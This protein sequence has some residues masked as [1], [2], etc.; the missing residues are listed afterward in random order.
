[1]QCEAMHLESCDLA[2]IL[3]GLA[4][5][6]VEV[7]RDCTANA[8]LADNVTTK[9]P[10]MTAWLIFLPSLASALPHTGSYRTKQSQ[11]LTSGLLHLAE[12][13]RADLLRAEL[14]APAGLHPGITVRRLSSRQELTMIVQN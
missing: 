12:H 13:V 1:M 6:V 7:G 5:R 3:R 8:Q 11:G 2:G 4:L 14:L 9:L 10:V